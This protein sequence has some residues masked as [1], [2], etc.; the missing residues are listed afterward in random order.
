MLKSVM[1]F[2][3]LLSIAACATAPTDPA[4]STPTCEAGRE[5]D[6]KWQAA[7]RWIEHR[8]KRR[9]AEKTDQM[10]RTNLDFSPGNYLSVRVERK[11]IAPGE[12]R[13]EATMYCAK[14]VGC[15][16]SPWEALQDFNRSV[17][18]S[19]TPVKT[20]NGH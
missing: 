12:Y 13:I 7:E 17:N 2:T 18:S 1:A 8:A 3:L 11:S 14:K 20:S 10:M 6:V 16:P 19:W 4:V 15:D 9:V 5:C